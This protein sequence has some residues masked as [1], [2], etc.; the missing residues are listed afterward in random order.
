MR[1][2]DSRESSK[3]REAASGR[4]DGACP[5]GKG[6]RRRRRRRDTT[7][8]F[9]TTEGRV[10]SVLGSGRGLSFVLFR[11]RATGDGRATEEEEEE[12]RRRRGE[13]WGREEVDGVE[14]VWRGRALGGGE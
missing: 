4:R 5:R 12:K 7:A 1:G 8:V 6:R 2:R 14:R 3:E 13:A 9:S 11:R 10:C